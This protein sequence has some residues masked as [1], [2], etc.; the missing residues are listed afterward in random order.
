M[1][2]AVSRALAPFLLLALAA[3]SGKAPPLTV[4]GATLALLPTTLLMDAVAPS[5][6]RP[7]A[8]IGIFA[9]AQIALQSFPGATAAIQGIE[10]HRAMLPEPDI[11]HERLFAYLTELGTALEVNVPDYLNRSV[12]RAAALET[13]VQTLTTLLEEGGRERDALTT[14]IANLKQRE[15][16]QRAV[17]RDIERSI[18]TALD[19]AQY[20]QG[21]AQQETLSP[22]AITAASLQEERRQ[23]EDTASLLDDLLDIGTERLTAIQQNRDVLIAGLRVVDVPGIEDLRILEKRGFWSR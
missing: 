12:D 15:Q 16:Q 1:F 10:V 19:D 2:A 9:S 5:V 4:R 6:L 11:T 3:C 8:P 14:A 7:A 20:A 23:T 17:V 18:N 22:E 21:G 13:Y